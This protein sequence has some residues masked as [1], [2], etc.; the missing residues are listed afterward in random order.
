MVNEFICLMAM[1]VFFV[2]VMVCLMDKLVYLMDVIVFSVAHWGRT[3]I[4]VV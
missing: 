2:D 4:N 3:T 1:L